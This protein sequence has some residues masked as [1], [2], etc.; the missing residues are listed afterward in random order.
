MVQIVK[1]TA[2]LLLIA[3]S[4]ASDVADR[5]THQGFLS[6]YVS[7][8]S[9]AWQSSMSDYD[10]FI[11]PAFN[12]AKHGNGPDAI[13]YHNNP[14]ERGSFA[15][16]DDKPVLHPT[17]QGQDSMASMPARGETSISNMDFSNNPISVSA[18]GIGLLSLV[19]MLIVRLR[20][21]SMNSHSALGDTV[22]EMKSQDA[23]VNSGRVGWGQQSHQQ[24][25]RLQRT[26][27]QATRD[28]YEVLGVPRGSD[29]RTIK[30]A[31]RE[32]ARKWHPDV[33]DTAEAEEKYKEISQAYSTLSD[34]E[35][36]ARYDQ[37]GDVGLGGG[38]P[39]G[40]PGGVQV[41]LEDIFD[42][43]F[44][45]GMGGGARQQQRNGPMQGDD[46]RADLELDFKKACFGGQEKVRISHL[47][48]CETCDATGIKPGAKVR[49]CGTCKGSGVV[50]QVTRT[51]LGS[52]QTQTVCSTC[53]G[54]G[55]SVDAYCTTCNGQGINRKAKQVKVTIPCGVDTGNKLRV[56]GEGDAGLRGGP[57]GDLY[58]FLS[59]RD[60]PGFERDGVD[61]K[62][63]LSVNA[64][65]AI[66]GCS[67]SIE[68]LEEPVEV[69]VPAGTQP[70]TKLRLKGKGVPALG[71][72]TQRGDHYV[73]VDVDIPKKLDADTQKIVE[74][75]RDNLRK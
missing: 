67:E 52:F 6:K 64:Y 41:N 28:L 30:R 3:E 75:L 70:G 58:I 13:S 26:A 14:V 18:I 31:F 25:P 71:K 39:G 27:L 55:Q 35:K 33:N 2:G 42:S 15:I 34:P 1:L 54:S 74:Q 60:Q 5:S 62:T 8:G 50:M 49:T 72:S 38:G 7:S 66:L 51:P 47:E 23:Q 73:V 45:G 61:I 19:T 48:K 37:F 69:K 21:G 22:M 20:R 53:R 16:V 59:V 32:A 44:G 11:T 12:R 56:A 57:S 17:E 43:F 46:L 65:D 10:N 63:H 4:Q 68:T 9:D 36:K 24:A 29:D 40:Y